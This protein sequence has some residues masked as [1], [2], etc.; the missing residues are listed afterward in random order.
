MPGGTAREAFRD[1]RTL[2]RFGVVADISDGQLLDRF[3]DRR[4]EGAEEAFTMLVRRHGPM[5]FG[6]CRRVL[7]NSH[8]A[9]DAFQTT[10]LVLARKAS[11]IARR[12]T[13]ANWLYGVALRTARD[14]RSRTLRRRAKEEHV[15]NL[16]V[17]HALDENPLEELPAILDEELARLP[18]RLRMPVL[19]CELE[20]LSRQEAAMRL[21]IPEGTLS[22]RLARA[23]ALLRERL[24]R[25]GLGLSAALLTSGLARE[26]QAAVVPHAVAENTIR[27]ATLIAAGCSLTGL[28]AASVHTLTEEVCQAMLFAKLKGLLFGLVTFGAVTTGAIVL[29]QRPTN[30]SQTNSAD[31]VIANMPENS[32]QSK[33]PEGVTTTRSDPDR[34]HVVEQKL[35]RILE[36]LGKSGTVANAPVHTSPPALANTGVLPTFTTTVGTASVPPSTISGTVSSP[37]GT[38]A[39]PDNGLAESRAWRE[40]LQD[41]LRRGSTSPS[42]ERLTF[43]EQ[44]MADLERRLVEIERRVNQAGAFRESERPSRKPTS[45]YEQVK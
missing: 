16:R 22:S 27:A 37:P 25:R 9:E 11:T 33:P 39:P 40:L 19:L 5:V 38:P 3:V 29:A 6:V 1:L 15:N 31:G 10:F 4:D 14:A 30:Y 23:K 18:A 28:V 43:L 34:L 36:A 41:H 20:T 13:L 12:E 32:L 44:R 42:Q 35:D 7:S 8:E 26:A 21:S 24:T 45:D 17:I 2:F